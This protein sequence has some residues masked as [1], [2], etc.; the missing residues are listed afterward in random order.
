MRVVP[1]SHVS[2]PFGLVTR[3]EHVPVLVHDV[4]PALDVEVPPDP[5]D[6]DAIVKSA[7]LRSAYAP[8]VVLRRIRA[9]VVALPLTVQLRLPVPLVVFVDEL[10]GVHVAPP[11]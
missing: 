8:S 2:P 4:V 1:A 3:T 7:S 9:R 11:S 6:D 5:D 10:V